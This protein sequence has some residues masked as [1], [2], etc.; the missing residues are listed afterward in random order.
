MPMYQH[1]ITDLEYHTKRTLLSQQRADKVSTACHWHL[2]MN[3]L[4]SIAVEKHYKEFAMDQNTIYLQKLNLK[5]NSIRFSREKM[6]HY[7]DKN[8][9]RQKY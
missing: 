4:E 7:T 5:R 8:L 3:K 2:L 6:V 1:Q 9:G